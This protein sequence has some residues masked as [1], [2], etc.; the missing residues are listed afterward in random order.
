MATASFYSNNPKFY[1]SVDC[2]IFGYAE[3]K[4][5]VLL[6]KR[7]FEPFS[8]ELSLEGGFVQE[9]E[10]VDEAAKRVL[11]ER[12]G[13]HDVYITQ[14]GAFGRAD[15]DEG[16]RVITVAYC[17]LL[18]SNLCDKATVEKYDGL[19]ADIDN[20]PELHFDHNEIVEV[21]LFHLR[22]YVGR[23]PIGF[24][25]LPPMFTL[26]QLQKMHEAVLGVPLDKRNF[27][28][29]VAEMSFIEKTDKIDKLHS[30]RGAA[31]YQYNAEIFKKFN[32][33]KL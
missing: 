24:Y 29:R 26:S 15:R 3:G 23:K 32:K 20:M 10:D 11:Y 6:Q 27:R 31:L 17:C 1:V 2:V 5:K 18:D 7:N 13:V 28:K 16:A 30:K 25:L 21:A 22:M 12:T 4:L 33:F 19:W 14:V 9:G 8:G